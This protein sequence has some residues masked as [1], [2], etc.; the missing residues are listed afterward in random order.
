MLIN[1]QLKKIK[2]TKN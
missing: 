2:Q 1:V